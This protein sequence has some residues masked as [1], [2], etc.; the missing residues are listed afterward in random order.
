MNAQEKEFYDYYRILQVHQDAEPEIIKSAYRRLA[1]MNHPDTN[2]DPR[3]ADKMK[4]I[5]R[6]YE[7][8]SDSDQRRA[9]HKVWIL[10]HQKYS[11]ADSNSWDHPG[12]AAQQ[13]LDA[14]F[15]NI[16]QKDWTE[17][18]KSLTQKDRCLIPLGD[19]CEWKEAVAELYQMGSYVIK[20][21]TTYEKCFIGKTEYEK[22]HVFS[23]FLTDRDRRSGTVSEET[24]TKYVVWDRDKWG[25]CLGYTQLKPIIYKMKYLAAQAPHMDPGR[26][27]MEAML[28]YDKLTGFLS[29]S[30]LAENMEKEIARL[31]R[32]RSRF[33]IAVLTIE[34]SGEAPGVSGAEYMQMCLSDAAAQLKKILRTTDH[35]ARLS[36]SQLAVLLIETGQFAAAN[37][38]KRFLHAIRPGE[39]LE[40]RVDGSI[41]PYQGESA[42]DTCIRA[43]QDARTEIITGKDN[44]RKYHIKLDG[45]QI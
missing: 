44:V 10:N 39:G 42:E 40:Y 25:V 28:K 6:A 2:P 34:P 35:A 26:V 41:T 8:I 30:G 3:A 16:L 22:V 38:L 18:Y 11:A 5:N 14:Y 23:V 27:Y 15:R 21:F 37:A 4:L 29:R 17:A 45:Q 20:P 33:C 43:A 31:R 36:E 32:F 24:Y 12:A 19:F 13:T 9:Y 1:Q 7:T